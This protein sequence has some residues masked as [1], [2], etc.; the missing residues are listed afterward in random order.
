[1]GGGGG[2][3]AAAH[4]S[5]SL[6]H[7][8]LACGVDYPE[9]KMGAWRLT[10]ELQNRHVCTASL[11]VPGASICPL[12]LCLAAPCKVHWLAFP[13]WLLRAQSSFAV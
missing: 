6:G 3:E 9:I 12:P 13:G 2:G 11:W 5:L 8:S 10:L 1:M 7:Y 4:W